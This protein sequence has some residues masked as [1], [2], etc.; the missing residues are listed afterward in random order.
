MNRLQK[1][2][3]ASAFAALAYAMGLAPA[4]VPFPLLPFLRFDLAEIPDLMSFIL[5]GWKYGLLTAFAHWYALVM[6]AQGVFAPPPIPQLMKFTA[7][8]AMF[9]G[10]YVGLR[11]AKRLKRGGVV[12]TTLTAVLARAGVMAPITFALYYWWFP[13]I[14]LP[15]GKRA[16]TAAGF[17]VE[18]DLAAA[19]LITAFTAVF[20]AISALYLV[21]LCFSIAKALKRA[22]GPRI[23]LAEAV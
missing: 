10:V 11:L 16:L 2:A 9:L 21:P 3:G 12:L 19:T 15:F 14:Y 8:S 5:F 23:A 20:N 7:V 22:L 17:A 4:S 18:S 13:S 6:T 1:L